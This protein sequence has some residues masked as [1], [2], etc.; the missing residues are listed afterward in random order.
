MYAVRAWLLHRE[1]DEMSSSDDVLPVLLQ[2]VT[3][4]GQGRA[5]HGTAKRERRGKKIK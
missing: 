1:V 5:V 3:P 2:V 4:G